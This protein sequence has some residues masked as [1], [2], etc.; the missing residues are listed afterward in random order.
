MKTV[1]PA[2]ISSFCVRSQTNNMKDFK[3]SDCEKEFST[4]KLIIAHLK[5]SHFH[6][7]NYKQI[8]CVVNYAEYQNACE[9]KFLTFNGLRTHLKKCLKDRKN[10]VRRDATFDFDGRQQQEENCGADF[11]INNIVESFAEN[12]FIHQVH[13]VNVPKCMHVNKIFFSI[14]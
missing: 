8:K 14:V 4:Q 10:A 1:K 11:N 7:D 12:L 9:S 13:T 2:R 3:C 6:K 5:Q